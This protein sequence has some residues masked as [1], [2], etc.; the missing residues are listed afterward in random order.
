M[1]KANLKAMKPSPIGAYNWVN[2]P[3]ALGKLSEWAYGKLAES[4]DTGELGALAAEI[5]ARFAQGA[6]GVLVKRLTQRVP[7]SAGN[8]H[9]QYLGL[10]VTGTGASEPQA[11]LAY[12][13]AKDEAA[14]PPEPRLGALCTGTNPTGKRR[15]AQ[16]ELR[17]APEGFNFGY[18]SA[19]AASVMRSS[20]SNPHNIGRIEIFGQASPIQPRSYIEESFFFV[21]RADWERRK[22][23]TRG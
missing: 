17:A 11:L 6:G 2:L 16:A 14:E 18:A 19:L 15:P 12:R 4:R 22:V 8:F 3:E 1:G 23:T 13:K 10:Q 20:E 21:S 5:E 7:D 9:P